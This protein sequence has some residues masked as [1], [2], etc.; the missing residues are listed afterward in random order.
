MKDK[1][2][3]D[4]KHKAR[5][6]SK[7]DSISENKTRQSLVDNNDSEC[8]TVF[9]NFPSM[10]E[11]KVNNGKQSIYLDQLHFIFMMFNICVV[12]LSSRVIRFDF[13]AQWV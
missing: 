11:S 10:G 13:M 9:Q 12:L 4:K 8:E 7:D 5:Q 2:E 3:N 1:T 6:T